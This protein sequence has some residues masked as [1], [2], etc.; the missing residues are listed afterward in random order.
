MSSFGQDFLQGFL[1]GL[2]GPA[3]KDYSHASKTFRT[4]YFGLAPKQKFTFHVVFNINTALPGIQQLLGQTPSTISKTVKSI[5]LP[6]YQIQVEELNQYNRKRYVQNKINYQPVQIV[7]HDDNND[8]VRQLWY[9][10]YQ[11]FYKDA[12][13][14]YQGN[15]AVRGSPGVDPTPPEFNYNNNDLYQDKRPVTDFGFVGEGLS[16]PPN[17]GQG[18]SSKPQFFKDITIY[19][20]TQHNFAAYTLI[21][22][23]IT[24]FAHDTYDYSDGSSPMQNTMTVKYEL[25]KYYRG[26]LNGLTGAQII[27]GF[28]DGNYDRV[29]SSIT[30]AGG[31]A[32]IL[33]RNGLLDAGAG[34]FSDLQ[35]GNPVG[36]ILKGVNTYQTF[37]DKNLKSIAKQEV[38]REARSIIAA[39]VPNAVAA[40]LPQINGAL[41]NTFPTA[42][43]GNNNTSYTTPPSR[44]KTG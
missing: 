36:A 7:F 14:G 37:K 29:T 11:Y 2:Q 20:L 9:A 3:L 30:R 12:I 21:N 16:T 27:P 1:G 32:T 31:S 5:Q 24:D 34:I 28:V 8:N 6:S 38:N 23:L 13:Y 17:A 10:Y 41:V 42:P 4:D 39:T 19:G 33:G 25:V 43:K 26:A 18:L 44:P 40:Q 22:P 15:P 35:N